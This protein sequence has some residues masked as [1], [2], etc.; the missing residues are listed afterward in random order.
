MLT[1]QTAILDTDGKFFRIRGE[2]VFLKVVT[3]GPFP[4][5]RVAHESELA[6]VAEAGFHAIRVYGDPDLAM[7]DAAYGHGLLVMVGLEWEWDRVFTGAGAYPI[8]ENAKQEVLN[9]LKK[10]G[11]H[12]SVVSCFVANEVRPDIARWI[13]VE[14]TRG[15]LEQLIDLVKLE[16]PHLLVA[17][18]SYPSSEY[19]EP[20]NADFTAM[21]VYLE[22][23]DAYR[24]YLQRLHHIAGDRPVLISEF[25]L[26]TLRGGE[27]K[28]AE[29]LQWSLQVTQSEGLAGWTCFAWSDLWYNGG[30]LV[31]DWAFGLVKADGSPKL[32]LRVVQEDWQESFTKPLISVIICVY[33]G[34]SRIEDAV[35]S[36]RNLNYPNYEVLVVDDGSTDETLNLLKKFDFIRVIESPHKGLSAA[37]NSGASAAR[38]EI[39]S[40]IDDDCQADRDYLYWLAKAY[41]ENDWGACGGPNIPPLAEGEDEAVVAC[42]PGAPSHVMLGDVEAEHIPGCHLSVRKSVF[43]DVGGFS[44]QYWVAG[45][46]V[47]FCWRLREAGYRIGFH[48][49]SFVWHRRRTSWLRY[50]KQQWGYGKA[51]AI[52]MRDHPEYFGES[53][54]RWEGCVYVGSAAGVTDTSVI[55]HGQAGGAP[56]QMTWA[57]MM[58]QR[59]LPGGWASFSAQTKLSLLTVIHPYVRC[60]SRLW[61]GGVCGWPFLRWRGSSNEVNEWLDDFVSPIEIENTREELIQRFLMA[62]WQYAGD[63]S[64]WDLIYKES[65][66]LVVAERLGHDWRV[67]VRISGSSG[68]LNARVLVKSG[69]KSLYTERG[70]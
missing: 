9:Q 2:R 37:R 25:G 54:I 34:E 51:E 47:D 28:H 11:G 30:K 12:P 67:R 43:E 7:L 62:G 39:L 5:G 6:R 35:G 16:C 55:Y 3:Y 48:G 68:K 45:D 65:K 31:D 26:D 19:L 33:N 4:E 14:E 15:S 1:T 27:K 49:A 50:L 61:F 17:Y 10:W 46:D 69:G 20:R 63:Y 8:F 44:E 58:P 70:K 22:S 56:Y 13:G 21:N 57:A 23:E 59:L 41:S 18:S 66:L 38:G 64:E 42:A 32:A 29:A 40:Y 36:L 53:G 60:L 52:L 24:S